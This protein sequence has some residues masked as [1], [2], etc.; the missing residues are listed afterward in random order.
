MDRRSFLS[1]SL[2]TLFWGDV[3]SSFA[4]AAELFSHAPAAFDVVPVVGDGKWIWNEPPKDEE[5]YLEPRPFELKIGIELK[6]SGKKSQVIAGTPVPVDFPEQKIEDQSIEKKGCDAEIRTLDNGAASLIVRSSH[7]ASKVVKATATFKLLLH[8][9]YQRY[10][11]DKFP[12]SQKLEDDIR[13]NFLGESPGIQS[14]A[15]EVKEL[16]KQLSQDETHPWNKAQAFAQWIPRNIRGKPGRYT[17]VTAALKTRQGDC[18]E[19]SG[20]FVALCR[21]SGIPAR[22]ILVPNHAWAE[23]YL[24]DNDGKGHWIPAHTACYFWFGWT[25]VHQLTLQKGDRIL[26]PE[27]NKTVR[28]QEDFVQSTGGRA[29]PRFTAELRPLPRKPGDAPGPGA[30]RKEP[31][32]QWTSMDV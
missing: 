10:S 32:G 13:S 28:L 20:L 31:T 25:G 14:K 6:T 21:A 24:V 30:K 9:Q 4:H 5:G 7:S 17:S 22:L 3:L 2:G 16:A 23:F 8:K 12:P 29:T 19:M 1:A 26:M 11:K 18:E 27:L 15:K